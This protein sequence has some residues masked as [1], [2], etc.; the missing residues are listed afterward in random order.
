MKPETIVSYLMCPLRPVGHD[1][2]HCG[3][4]GRDEAQ[5][6]QPASGRRRMRQHRSRT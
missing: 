2:R 4:H 1:A 3:T 6:E 5:M